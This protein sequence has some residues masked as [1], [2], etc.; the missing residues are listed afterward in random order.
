MK[1]FKKISITTI[2]ISMLMSAYPA[3]NAYAVDYQ[4]T[5]VFS[6]QNRATI[7]YKD[8]VQ[9]LNYTSFNNFLNNP[10]IPGAFKNDE[11]Q[12]IVGK[13]CGQST[14]D[15][16]SK[17]YYNTLEQGIKEGD[18]V[19][20]AVYFHN[21]G[22][23]PYVKETSVKS[24]QD[25]TNVKIG[26]VFD[27]QDPNPQFAQD[28]LRPQGYIYADNNQ[29]RTT[30]ADTNSVIKNQDG[31]DLKTAT[32]DM[33]IMLGE[34]GLYFEPIKD[35]AWLWN[36][37]ANFDKAVK[38]GDELTFIAD[39]NETPIAPATKANLAKTKVTAI[40]YSPTEMS[41]TFD[42]LPGCFRYSGFVYFDVKVVKKP[43]P[44]ASICTELKITKTDI[45]DPLLSP[46][47][48]S[49][50]SATPTFSPTNTIPDTTEILWKTTD[51][52]GKFW[53]K[54]QMAAKDKYKYMDITESGSTAHSFPDE[55]IYYTGFGT[56]TAEL[57]GI[58]QFLIG[59]TCTAKFELL[60]P[61]IC[62][63]L[64]VNSPITITEGVI[65]DMMAAATNDDGTA[66]KGQIKYWVDQAVNG[67]FYTQPPTEYPY[68]N[69]PYDIKVGYLAGT[70]QGEVKKAGQTGTQSATIAQQIWTHFVGLKAGTLVHVQAYDPTG[71]VDVTKCQQDFTI[72]PAPKCTSIMLNKDSVITEDQLATFSAFSR[73]ANGK[74]YNGKITYSVPSEYGTFYTDPNDPAV[75]NAKKNTSQQSKQYDETSV[76][77]LDLSKPIGGEFCTNLVQQPKDLLPFV[78]KNTNLIPSVI[79]M[80]M[81]VMYGKIPTKSMEQLIQQDLAFKLKMLAPQTDPTKLDMTQVN[82][83]TN[84][85]GT[86][87]V[88]NAIDTKLLIKPNVVIP[89]TT[90]LIKNL[91]TTGPTQEQMSDKTIQMLPTPVDAQIL[92]PYTKIDIIDI[93][94]AD[95]YINPY[96]TTNDYTVQKIPGLKVAKLEAA[97]VG[98]TITVDPNTKV[99]FVPKKGSD[100]KKVISLYVNCTSEGGCAQSFE[101]VPVPKE[102]PIVCEAAGVTVTDAKTKQKVSCLAKG[103]YFL[104]AGFY[105]DKNTGTPVAAPELISVKWESTDPNGVFTN[106]TPNSKAAPGKSPFIASLSVKYV[107]EGKV[108]ATLVAL[109]G[110]PYTQKS[111]SAFIAPCTKNCESLSF[112]VDGKSLPPSLAGIT[113]EKDEKF[114]LSLNTKD[115]QGDSLPDT[116]KLN[117]VWTTNGTLTDSK[118]H[119]NGEPGK[120]NT[121]LSNIPVTLADTDKDGQITVTL[122]PTDPMYSAQCK[123][124]LSILQPEEPLT[125]TETKVDLKIGNKP[126]TSLVPNEIYTVSAKTTY[127]K[128]STDKNIVSVDP[129]VGTVLALSD[130]PIA[131][132]TQIETLNLLKFFGSL[133]EQ[134]LKNLKTQP[135]AGNPA[136]T[137]LFT[138]IPSQTVAN[139]E[140]VYFVTY[141]DTSSTA[142]S[143]ANALRVKAENF[144]NTSCDKS[145]TLNY[146]PPVPPQ[147]PVETVCE[148][149]NIKTPTSPWIADGSKELFE[150]D[151]TTTPKNQANDLT[152]VWEVTK[153]N[154][155]WSNGSDTETK[156]GSR[157]NTLNDAE[158]GTTVE[159]YAVDK[160]NNKIANCSDTIK[161]KTNESPLMT[162]SVY[163]TE[164]NPKSTTKDLLNIGSTATKKNVTYSIQFKANSAKE[165]DLWESAMKDDQI[166]GDKGGNLE[167]QGMIINVTEGSDKY[168]IL[169]DGQ[170]TSESGDSKFTDYKYTLK[171]LQ[172]K[173][174]CEDGTQNN[175][176]VCIDDTDF[177]NTVEN[178]KDAEKLTFKNLKSDTVIE[179][180]VQMKNNTRINATSCKSLSKAEGCGEEFKNTAKFEATMSGADNEK[181]S[182][183]AKVIVICPYVLTRQAGDVFF[184]DV[185][186]TGIDV[187]RCSEVKSTP[188]LVIQPEKV[189]KRNLEKSGAG[190][191]PTEAAFLEVP[192]HDICRYSNSESNVKGYNDILNNFSS[193]I[194]EMRADVAQTWKEAYINASINA[195]VQRISRF[196]EN[197]TTKTNLPSKESLNDPS[198]PNA[199][200]GVFVKEGG[201]LTI[202]NGKDSIFTIDRVK[203]PSGAE[204][205]PA[206]QTYIV[207]GGTLH[208]TSD[209]IYGDTT[210]EDPNTIPSAAF[211]VIDGNIIIDNN[212]TQIDAI[213]MAVDTDNS[214]DG[215]IT[216]GGQEDTPNL[217]VINGSLIGNVAEL[218]ATRTGAG[219]PTQ[220]QGSVTV[221]YDE[222]ILLN[223]PPGLS[224]LLNVTQSLIPG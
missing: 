59:K 142:K 211:I 184:H 221:R 56:V 175:S 49:A 158:S 47:T 28:W 113:A 152:Y 124:D 144:F 51:T 19:R 193:T 224:D 5:S 216:N 140:T 92:F 48:A 141:T 147:P 77:N 162:K 84:K 72:S 150:I 69:Q 32:D 82:P 182:A 118:G 34:K 191:L 38:V 173:H 161:A 156:K 179:I 212:V 31:S 146:V 100:G 64:K 75:K 78:F 33:A 178:F 163:V 106:M 23:D 8:G 83:A 149:L 190:D 220:D 125:C 46:A 44:T 43:T 95:K 81:E 73:D 90:T 60:K 115:N 80:G 35:S 192:S 50:V 20:F 105:T 74:T 208:I 204:K 1:I 21:N 12:F 89:S 79:D 145:F 203:D 6:P 3:N 99:Y 93:V 101:I 165:V 155:E 194:C 120:F 22:G 168:T 53:K 129:K 29:Y 196:G 70:L 148:D 157:K 37:N 109:S 16:G 213:I 24:I 172:E 117:W 63:E 104:N 205:V 135:T 159:V 91:D 133:T 13:N 36:K 7:D 153:G 121:P 4:N 103:E 187:S 207:K 223:T 122:D 108:T 25:A 202:G 58:E 61:Q 174:N 107:G 67:K 143:L 151:V 206:G 199:K 18:T 65:S 217:L 97:Q 139:D 130:N 197:L 126:E 39:S 201:T 209:I 180:K 62:K 134:N 27:K 154:G 136:G 41:I 2:I 189:I 42:R 167:Y 102:K 200:S 14:T 183:T 10:N 219:D 55:E 166:K 68:M 132:T 215:K 160:N 210:Y 218:F 127:S 40:N 198:I 71:M 66:F 170:Y 87:N 164:T 85:F 112:N 222:R 17:P 98:S 26:V 88:F 171:S 188:G 94:G 116:T 181:G 96:G 114:S 169:R 30:I 111:C 185:L 186:D 86:N 11:R 131:K 9:G 214:G 137:N 76:G 176:K 15:C 52:T 123:A 119:K 138:L 45:N 57:S 195:N 110:K 128:P 177:A 54:I